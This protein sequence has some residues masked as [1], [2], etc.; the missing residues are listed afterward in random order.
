MHDDDALV[1][2]ATFSSNLEASLARGA[3]EAAG[4]RAVVPNE[5]LG[6]LSRQR[7]GAVV[8]E[9]RVFEADRERALVALRRLNLHLV[10]DPQQDIKPGPTGGREWLRTAK[11]L[12]ALLLAFLVLGLIATARNRA[13]QQPLGTAGAHAAR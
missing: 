3:L 6:T 1:T 7:G 5:A 11:V 10:T 12:V 9:L 13:G 4:I 2:V 8:E